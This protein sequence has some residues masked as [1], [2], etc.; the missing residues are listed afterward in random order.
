[1][2]Q[3]QDKKEYK[4]TTSVLKDVSLN[5]YNLGNL[6]LLKRLRETMLSAKPELCIERA[7][8]ITSFFRNQINNHKSIQ[9]NYAVAVAFFLSKKKPYYFDDNLLAGT[10]TSKHFGAPLYPELTGMTIWPELDTIGRREKNPIMISPGDAELLD[11]D[12][13]PFWIERS[14]L[15]RTRK[16]YDNPLCMKLFERM[17][18]FIAGK[19]GCISHTVP[20]FQV[21]LHKGVDFIVREVADKEAEIRKKRYLTLA[22]RQ[23]IDFF[24]AVQI[25]LS[26]IIVYAQNLM[27]TQALFRNQ[28][29]S[30]LAAPGQSPPLPS[31][32]LMKTEKT[33]LMI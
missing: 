22:D 8:H 23:K 10:T 30:C 33:L 7:V 16:K 3:L 9:I 1:M 32:G 6:P 4:L 27:T 13:L 21:A 17:T 15:E 12:I 20:D 25:S 29:R 19:A 18:Y 28:L 31:E 11:L 14:I 24:K 26:G 2:G 5:K